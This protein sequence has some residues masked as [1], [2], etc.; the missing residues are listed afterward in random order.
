MDRVD[1][2]VVGA[3][4]VGLAVA[5][6]LAI[7]GREVV[8]VES[9]GAIGT[10]TSSRNSEVIHAGLGYPAGSHKARLCVRGR[11]LLYR[12]AEARGI[13][14]RRIGKLIVAVDE[15]ELPGLEKYEKLGAAAGVTDLQRLRAD[16]IRQ[17]EPAVRAIAGLWSPSTGIVDSHA[18]MLSYLSDA[19]AHGALLALRSPVEGGLATGDGIVLRVG[20]DSPTELL[21]GTVVNA[22]GLG[23][24]QLAHRL[25][26]MP[27][28]LVPPLHY[29]IGHYFTL[30]GASPFRHLVYPVS[31]DASARVH[32][33]LDLAGACRFG[34]DH[35]W[36]DSKDYRFD[37]RRAQ[38]FY[39][40]IRRYWPSLPDGALVPGYT[41]IRPRIAGP[42]APLTTA[43]ADFVFQGEAVHGV[44]GLVNLFGIE[45]PGLTSSLAIGEYV[46]SLVA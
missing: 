9:Q 2:A 1:C 23:A 25:E 28:A 18:L 45:S 20:G 17:R 11:A 30:S 19:E 31:R 12:Y 33:T 10:E 15:E 27:G 32:A 36:I 3:G 22:A 16:E 14:H 24:Q 39:R 29:A 35:A 46:A 37:E 43:A 7:A 13:G 38:G 26:G 8:I 6:A 40:G 42:D 5:R 21:C 34:P 41:G 4:V 44:R